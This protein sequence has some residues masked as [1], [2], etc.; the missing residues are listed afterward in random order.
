MVPEY[1]LGNIMIKCLNNYGNGNVRK[2]ETLLG[3]KN[4]LMAPS[5]ACDWLNC[6]LRGSRPQGAENHITTKK[7]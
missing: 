3:F 1:M 6:L 4:F 7:M 5:H 2:I